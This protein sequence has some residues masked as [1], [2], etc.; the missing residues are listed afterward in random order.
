M[1]AVID[2]G[3]GNLRSVQ[4]ALLKVGARARVTA[5]PAEL[6]RA[7]KIVFPGVGAF[8]DAMAAPTAFS[9]ES[10][11]RRSTRSASMSRAGR[12]RSPRACT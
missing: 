12:R 8:G 10:G 7:E 5:S 1:I 2:Y 9:S 3:M 11:S 6:A 4:K